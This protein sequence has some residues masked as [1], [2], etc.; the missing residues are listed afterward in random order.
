MD[1]LF[2]LM[3]KRFGTNSKKAGICRP[4]SSRTFCQSAEEWFLELARESEHLCHKA[5]GDLV[6]S[7]RNESYGGND[8]EPEAQHQSKTWISYGSM[9]VMGSS[10]TCKDR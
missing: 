1:K 4:G 10:A 2:F 7:I 9:H 5:G 8:P 6:L 3:P